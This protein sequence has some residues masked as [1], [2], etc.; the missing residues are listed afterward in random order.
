MSKS[1]KILVGRKAIMDFLHISSKDLFQ[2]FI[3]SGLPAELIN[4][5]WWAHTDNLEDYFKHVT[6]IS[7][8]ELSERGD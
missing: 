6:R 2:F 7:R 1:D 4:N 3:K 8:K 5:R